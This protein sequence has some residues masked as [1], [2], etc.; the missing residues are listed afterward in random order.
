M[1]VSVSGNYEKHLLQD[2]KKSFTIECLKSSVSCKTCGYHLV[3]GWEGI[4]SKS[5]QEGIVSK[6]AQEGIV[7]KSAQEGIVSK[8]AQEGWEGIVSKSAQENWLGN[9]IYIP[10]V[11]NWLDLTIYFKN[12]TKQYFFPKLC[13]ST[14][15]CNKLRSQNELF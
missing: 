3:I 9:F 7:S 2:T 1:Y 11:I 14:K 5:A 4:V 8:S 13:A 10:G 15:T 6:S 12:T